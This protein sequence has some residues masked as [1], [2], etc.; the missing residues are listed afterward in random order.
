MGIQDY[1]ITTKGAIIAWIRTDPRM[2]IELHKRTAR[3]PSKDFKTSNYIPKLAH[4]R[5]T[6][7]TKMLMDY[8]KV[9]GDFRFIIRN[10]ELDIK[11]LI[12]RFSEGSRLPY[13][14]MSLNVLGAIS[15]VKPRTSPEEAADEKSPEEDDN[16][17]ISPNRKGNRENY[18]PKE[19][20]FR[21]I[22]AILNGFDAEAK[23]YEGRR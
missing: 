6:S 4:D 5:Q 23:S 7:V 9:N 21:N 22:T 11:V 20:I 18:I 3:A 15:P 10:D 12:K 1:Y 13:R 19:T 17:F 14:K 16:G 8:K 2:V